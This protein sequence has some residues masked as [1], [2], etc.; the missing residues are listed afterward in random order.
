RPY[1]AGAVIVIGF[2]YFEYTDNA[3]RFLANA[4][5]W[6]ITLRDTDGDGIPD[7]VETAY[8]LDPEDPSDADGDLDA[9]GLSNL[10]EFRLGTLLD[11]PDTDGDGLTDGDEV[12]AGLD[13]L[14][15]DTDGDGVGDAVDPYPQAIIRARLALPFAALAGV[16]TPVEVRLT[17][18]GELVG[19]P[20]PF[21][22]ETTGSATFAAAAD[23][24]TV[25]G[26][27]GTSSVRL[28]SDG[29][30]VRIAVTGP[31][32]E[33]L[34]LTVVDS[35]GFGIA[36]SQQIS[37][38]FE[39]DD[40][41]FIHGG[42]GDVWQWGAPSSGPRSARS[43][44]NLWATNLAGDYPDYSW[45]YLQTPEYDLPAGGA[46]GLSFWHYYEGECCCDYAWVMISVDGGAFVDLPG[47]AGNEGNR[48]FCDATGGAF[49]EVTAD[50]SA[51]AGHG[52][53]LRFQFRSDLSVTEP[54]WYIDDFA[55]TASQ[56]DLAVLEASGDEDGDGLTNAEELARGTNPFAADTDGDGLPDGVETGT[57]V[58]VDETDT[59]TDP[60]ERDT[61]GGGISD[62]R[63]VAWGL[64]PTN[65][66]DDPPFH[67]LA[68]TAYADMVPQTLAAISRFFP[69]CTTTESWEEDPAV[70]RA[71]LEGKQI[72]LLPNQWMDGFAQGIIFGEVLRDFARTGGLVIALSFESCNML[73]GAGLMDAEPLD[74]LFDVPLRLVDP[75]H[76]L[77][78]G[79]VPPITAPESTF[80]YA[81]GDADAT[82][83]LVSDADSAPVVASR[84]YG[85]GGVVLIGFDYWMYDDNAARFLANSVLSALA[86]RDTDGDG[87]P[88]AVETA[89]GLDPEDPSDAAG[90]IDGDGLSNLEEFRLGTLLDNP[91][92]DGDSLSDGDEVAA[93]LDPLDP[94]TDGDGIGDADDPYPQAIIRAR[95]ALPFAAIAGV[96]A[97]VEV[98]LTAGGEL[99][100]APVP[101]TLETTGS[102]AFAATADVGTVLE[103]G[104]TRSVRLQSEEGVARIAVTGTVEETLTFSVVDSDTFGIV[105][106]QDVVSDFE[107]DDGGF[108]HGGAGDVWQWGAPSSG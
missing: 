62:G 18:G 20:V 103:G 60:R 81:L 88:D 59:G 89:Y 93:G 48:F 50:L 72:L 102:A 3:A 45:S 34:S 37:E 94:D 64:D 108:T 57:G 90:D 97:A 14:D 19:V 7:A 55:I 10:E 101:F 100:G 61:D 21:T 15:P 68:W 49:Q 46:P 92:S 104:G 6:A 75:E 30:I 106:T 8:G 95:L 1:G 32:E 41:G 13:P 29:G 33:T 47:V 79:I 27:G 77:A 73:R 2:D 83:V 42:A 44:A 78:A 96:P 91:D 23:A 11:N 35:D 17:A 51:Y 87:I 26:G 80:S 107:A 84:P 43:G 25:L 99:V 39:A 58:F 4:V 85:A 76:P 24:G 56:S 38:D 69:D 9:D 74:W 28:Q 86:F 66:S 31:V 98:R 65:P 52:I 63:E 40:G 12:A 22:L 105:F 53:Q 71:E 82:V 54:G 16:A 36:F 5:E 70:L 67:I